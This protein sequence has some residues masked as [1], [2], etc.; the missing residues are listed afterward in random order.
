MDFFHR[1]D[2]RT[3][4]DYVPPLP[5]VAIPVEVRLQYGIID[6]HDIGLSV[7]T[8]SAP[9]ALRSFPVNYDIGG[10]FNWK[11]MLSD[12]TSKSKL[13]IN[14]SFSY[15][16][17]HGP[18]K[19]VTHS[20]YGLNDQKY[21]LITNYLGVAFIYSYESNAKI[22]ESMYAGFKPTFFN[23]SGVVDSNVIGTIWENEQFD[24][25]P[26]YPTVPIRGSMT[27]YSPF[28]GVK[29]KEP[30]WSYL[31]L[32]SLE[33]MPTFRISNGSL[34]VIGYSVAVGLHWF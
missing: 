1:D 12:S 11:W 26:D 30:L 5:P 6:N 16:T 34:H 14:T 17:A 31:P 25:Y 18:N 19:R 28:V 21:S 29:F 33:F 8:S 4:H 9:G 24:N 32:R 10:R 23:F 27:T 3:A 2:E 22:V 20:E 15:Y 13:A 7:W